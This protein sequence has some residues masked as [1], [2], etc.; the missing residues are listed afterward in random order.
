MILIP[1]NRVKFFQKSHQNGV[2]TDILKPNW[3]TLKVVIFFKVANRS[4]QH[5][6]TEYD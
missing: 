2:L 3:Q 6:V 1:I 5:L 4:L